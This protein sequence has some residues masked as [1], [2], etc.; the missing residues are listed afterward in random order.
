MGVVYLNR[1]RPWQLKHVA[2]S[3]VKKNMVS[4]RLTVGNIIPPIIAPTRVE[5]L[6]YAFLTV[7][8]MLFPFDVHIAALNTTASV[9]ITIVTTTYPPPPTRLLPFPPRPPIVPLPYRLVLASLK[10]SLLYKR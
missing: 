8:V 9:S 3:P 7:F 1:L 10:G 6:R 5:V 4:T 2:F